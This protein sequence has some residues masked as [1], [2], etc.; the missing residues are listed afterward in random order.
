M[1]RFQIYGRVISVGHAMDLVA[2]FERDYT[3]QMLR[4][5]NFYFVSFDCCTVRC[6]AVAFAD[7]PIRVECE[8][9]CLLLFECV[10]FLPFLLNWHT[11]LLHHIN[12]V[13]VCVHRKW[14]K[15]TAKMKYFVSPFFS[16][17]CIDTPNNASFQLD[18]EQSSCY[19]STRA[20][21]ITYKLWY[22]SSAW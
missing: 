16:F 21:I 11:Y 1:L 4:A 2:L 18:T 3:A 15:M 12:D 7:V 13:G 19:W 22:H 8:P 9:Y 6:V 5:P 10:F 20:N 14:V 17:K